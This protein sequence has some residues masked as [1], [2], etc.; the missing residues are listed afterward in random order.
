MQKRKLSADETGETQRS[1]DFKLNAG[2]HS[3]VSWVHMEVVVEQ[4]QST[5]MGAQCVLYD[6]SERKSAE[7]AQKFNADHDH[8]TG[9]AN[10]ARFRESL[11][12]RLGI[13]FNSMS[14]KV[15][16]YQPWSIL[17][18]M[19]TIG[20]VYAALLMKRMSGR[21]RSQSSH[22]SISW[23]SRF[24]RMFMLATP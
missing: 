3:A 4:Q 2:L 14:A 24:P 13:C 5:I 1:G 9:L 17:T 15:C 12:Q 22:L 23:T 18:P 11:S 20:V 8:L 7:E 6:I 10:R 16:L 19:L 21:E